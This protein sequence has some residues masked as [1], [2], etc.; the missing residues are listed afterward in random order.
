MRQTLYTSNLQ[1][2]L[3]KTNSVVKVD[4]NILITIPTLLAGVEKT[5]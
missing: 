5:E 3:H 2:Y 1:T 4:W